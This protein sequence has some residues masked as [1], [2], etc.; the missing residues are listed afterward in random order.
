M[1]RFPYLLMKGLTKRFILKY[2][3]YDFNMASVYTLVGGPLLLWGAIYGIVKWI[4]NTVSHVATPTGTIMLSV[5]PLILGTQ[6]II[7]AIN[8]DINSVPKNNK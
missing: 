3:I 5:L 8:I 7:A 4:E 2:L 1:T 6:F